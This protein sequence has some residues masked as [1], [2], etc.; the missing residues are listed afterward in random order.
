[1]TNYG[2]QGTNNQ[3]NSGQNVYATQKGHIR[4]TNGAAPPSAKPLLVILALDAVF[5]LYG[6][7]SY[8]GHNTSADAWRAGIFLALVVL[9]LSLTSRW[10][11]GRLR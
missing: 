3:Y 8:T 11:R 9:T 1:M 7:L 5:F 2:P 6:M 10:I 4:I